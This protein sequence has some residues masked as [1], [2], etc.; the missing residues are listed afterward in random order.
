[1][2]KKY[3]FLIREAL[4]ELEL[5]AI[6]QEYE[7]PEKIEKRVT[8]KKQRK[9]IEELLKTDFLINGEYIINND[10]TVSVNGNVNWES[11]KEK[12]SVTFKEVTGL[13][14]CM[15]SKLK[16]LES[17]PKKVVSFDCSNNEHLTS[18]EGGPEEAEEYYC[19]NCNLLSLEGKPKKVEYF[20]FTNNP[21]HDKL[22]KE[23]KL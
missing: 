5:D 11:E 8:I 12:L 17:S 7:D 13:F 3:K 23:G 1:M 21:I 20:N 2:S 6:S 16:S 10:F 15:K 14:S 9:E 18:L 19:N 4:E 22:K